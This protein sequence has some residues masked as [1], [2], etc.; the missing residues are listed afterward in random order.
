MND[1]SA[2]NFFSSS[3]DQNLSTNISC[4]DIWGAYIRVD[5]H[6]GLEATI[7]VSSN[8]IYS[9]KILR[10]KYMSFITFMFLNID[11]STQKVNLTH[12]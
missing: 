12:T 11:S 1:I 6:I 8:T 10:F 7:Q 3:L 4:W 9:P 5:Y 2:L